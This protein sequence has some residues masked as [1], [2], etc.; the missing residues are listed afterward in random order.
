[1]SR[2]EDQLTH[3]LP[4]PPQPRRVPLWQAVAVGLAL[5]LLLG[6]VAGVTAYVAADKGRSQANAHTD[7][8]LAALEADLTERRKAA[9]E[10]NA[11]RDQQLRDTERIVCAVVNRVQ[12]RDAEIERIRAEYRC[13]QQPLPSASP[14]ASP[15]PS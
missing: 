1:M 14:R 6:V 7:R 11:R 3:N 13:D 9:S 12:P 2:T 8:R 5:A 4:A 10:A 15:S